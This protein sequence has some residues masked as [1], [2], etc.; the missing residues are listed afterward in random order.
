MRPLLLGLMLAGFCHS[1]FADEISSAYTDLDIG[2][3]CATVAVAAEGDGQ[4]ANFVCPGY[5]GFP[6]LVYDDD[7]RQ[8]AFYGFPPPGDLAPAWE[9]FAAFNSVGPKIEWRVETKGETAIPFAAIHRRLVSDPEDPEKKIE[10]L[11]VSR[12]AQL[13]D[14]KSCA[15]GLVV[16]SGNPTANDMARRIADEQARDFVCGADERVQVSGEVPLPEFTRQEEP[17]Q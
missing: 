16:A 14:G 9:S 7:A 13:T 15:V 10:V 8:S 17:E 4:W 12:V 11:V 1:A 2:K 5:R 3:D 6:V